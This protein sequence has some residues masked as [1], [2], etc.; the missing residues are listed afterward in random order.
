MSKRIAL[1]LGG[2]GYAM[3]LIARLHFNP[4]FDTRL[5]SVMLPG[6]STVTSVPV[7]YLYDPYDREGFYNYL[8]TEQITNVVFGGNFRYLEDVETD[9]I[10]RLIMS[11]ILPDFTDEDHV[12]PIRG[13]SLAHLLDL[14]KNELTR[15]ELRP[16]SSSTLVPDYVPGLGDLVGKIDEI[17]AWPTP[18]EKVEELVQRARD[19]LKQQPT[20]HVRQAVVFDDDI[21]HESMD[22]T[23]LLLGEIAK[24]KKD[25]SIRTLVKICPPG[26]DKQMDPPVIGPKTLEA[27]A[28]AEVDLIVVDGESGI[29]FKKEAVSN[30]AIDA[31]IRIYAISSADTSA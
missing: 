8:R 25:C 5:V 12:A 6:R 16:I 7:D 10:R 22:S 2:G 23:E 29:M 14:F 21:K 30:L 3:D 19:E 24:T 26:Y 18:I 15:Q 17:S 11:F 1:V 9:D 13:E 31:G 4:V 27:A 20:Q 28:A